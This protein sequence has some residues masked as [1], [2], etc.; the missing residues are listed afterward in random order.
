MRLLVEIAVEIHP[1][2]SGDANRYPAIPNSTLDVRDSE[3][4]FTEPHL[5]TTPGG[6][7]PWIRRP[8][9]LFILIMLGILVLQGLDPGRAP[10][11]NLPPAIVAVVA[12]YSLLVHSLRRKI[13]VSS[14]GVIELHATCGVNNTFLKLE[15]DAPIMILDC[16]GKSELRRIQL[17]CSRASFSMILNEAEADRLGDWANAVTGVTYRK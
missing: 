14:D 3:Y 6:R 8:L 2:T 16:P 10:D 5:L 9:K 12:V 13:E 11:K 7:W 1:S 17:L 15:D 4:T